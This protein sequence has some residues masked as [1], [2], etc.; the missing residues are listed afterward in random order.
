MAAIQ[1]C[2]PLGTTCKTG[3]WHNSLL[4][5]PHDFLRCCQ[6]DVGNPSCLRS[7]NYRVLCH[8]QGTLCHLQGV[9]GALHHRPSAGNGKAKRVGDGLD[10]PAGVVQGV[11]AGAG[12]PWC[13]DSKAA[14]AGRG[15]LARFAD[16]VVVEAPQLPSTGR[17]GGSVPALTTAIEPTRFPLGA[18]MACDHVLPFR[19]THGMR[20]A[21]AATTRRRW[22][23]GDHSPVGIVKRF[24]SVGDI[25]FLTCHG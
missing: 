20:S 13:T 24:L 2:H 3:R 9:L 14:V 25:A 5:I 6:S 16:A 4:C 12:A 23:H 19:G 18:R 11:P 17:G 22:A 15:H 10:G 1:A 21:T 8:F 7:G